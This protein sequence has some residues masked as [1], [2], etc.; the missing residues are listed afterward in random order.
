MSM[1]SRSVIFEGELY[2]DCREEFSFTGIRPA[3]KTVR[4]SA[5]SGYSSEND[6]SSSSSDWKELALE[7]LGETHEVVLSSHHTI[8]RIMVL[9]LLISIDIFWLLPLNQNRG[10]SFFVSFLVMTNH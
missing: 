7:E 2:W 5:E 4:E 3:S 9:L 6:E 1:S 10:C 8:S